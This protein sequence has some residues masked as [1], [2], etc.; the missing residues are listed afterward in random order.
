MYPVWQQKQAAKIIAAV[1]TIFYMRHCLKHSWNNSCY[2]GRFDSILDLT[3]HVA[4]SSSVKFHQT[5]P[6]LKKSGSN[7]YVTSCI[8]ESMLVLYLSRSNILE[9]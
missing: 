1:S 9:L 6:V 5:L 4:K 7:Q 8:P 3:D 2:K